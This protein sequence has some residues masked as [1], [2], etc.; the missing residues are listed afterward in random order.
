MSDHGIEH[1][2]AEDYTEREIASVFKKVRVGNK[3][4]PLEILKFKSAL[5]FELALM[6][7]EKNWTQQF[8]VWR[9]HQRCCSHNHPWKNSFSLADNFRKSLLQ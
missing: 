3:L 1:P 5:L 4:E 6:D 2:Y 9:L 8:H 7:W